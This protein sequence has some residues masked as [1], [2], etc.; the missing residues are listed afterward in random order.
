VVPISLLAYLSW[1]IQT[2]FL[3]PGP[4]W[5]IPPGLLALLLS[6]Y[7]PRWTGGRKGRNQIRADLES[8]S[9]QVFIVT[10]LEAIK[11]EEAEDE[12]STYFLKMEDGSTLAMGGQ[13][14]YPYERRG[15]PWT[16][17]EIRQ[18]AHSGIFFGLSRVGERLKPSMLRGALP[19]RD[20]REWGL[21]SGRWKSMDVPFEE[22]RERLNE[23]D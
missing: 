21:L 16:M 5:L 9:V 8:N 10:A 19:L 14:L 6:H 20:V 4:W 22:V 13:Y 11:V 3:V 2:Q 12:G 17:F 23:H 18:A 1:I 15:F 7:S